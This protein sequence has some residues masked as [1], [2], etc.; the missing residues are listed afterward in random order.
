MTRTKKRKPTAGRAPRPSTPAPSAE[1]R[2]LPEPEVI[3][4]QT[5][6]P[7]NIL[8]ALSA[9]LLDL[10]R[11]KGYPPEGEATRREGHQGQPQ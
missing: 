1:S 3:F 6:E 7:G 2:A 8:P 10:A 11:R 9:L 5:D 4:I